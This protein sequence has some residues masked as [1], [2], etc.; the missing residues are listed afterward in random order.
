MRSSRAGAA[1]AFFVA[2]S[3][4]GCPPPTRAARAEVS[5]SP[6]PGSA[7]AGERLQAANALV[8]ARR[9]R[10]ALDVYERLLAAHPRSVEVL[11]RRGRALRYLGR[12]AEALADLDRALEIDPESVEAHQQ[13]GLIL[14]LLERH[15]EAASAYASALESQALAT[16]SIEVQG[17]SCEG[18]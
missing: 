1:L 10:E 14:R 5:S 8:Q 4:C 7:S 12:H 13:R 16:S 15:P 3:L 9:Y 18:G 2:A 17:M 6:T 11:T